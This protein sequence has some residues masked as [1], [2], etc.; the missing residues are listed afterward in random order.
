MIGRGLAVRSLNFSRCA[1]MAMRM[2]VMIQRT[3]GDHDADLGLPLSLDESDA[4]DSTVILITAHSDHMGEGLGSIDPTTGEPI[5][6]FEAEYQQL[7]AQ[8]SASGLVAIDSV[9]ALTHKAIHEPLLLDERGEVVD[10][11][12]ELRRANQTSLRVDLGD[13]ARMSPRRESDRAARE[14]LAVVVARHVLGPIPA[15]LMKLLYVYANDTGR[16]GQFTVKMSTLLDKMGYKRDDRGV[17]RSNNRRAVSQALLALQ[18]T[19]IGIN[20]A[21]EEETV[22]F[23]ASLLSS[24]E[25]RVPE[26]ITTLSAQQVFE[27]GL[28]ETVT[29]TINP[30][31]YRFRDTNGRPTP[32]YSLV[33]R[34]SLQPPTRTRGTNRRP[35]TAQTLGHYLASARPYAKERTLVLTRHALLKQ[36]GITD[37]NR[38][39]ATRTLARAL[40]KLGVDQVL[41]DY[42]PSPLP[43]DPDDKI[44]LVYTSNLFS[45]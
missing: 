3:S 23:V 27:R 2:N 31:W 16:T 19:Q 42:A 33:A 44:T 28:P 25:Y 17:H 35:T 30:R 4:T 39:N 11:G 6:A 20:I 43:L 18:F 38:A 40:D 36:A 37:R 13:I 10:N 14:E 29:I 21:R 34:S 7:I 15:T 12:W 22:G 5:P 9:Y 32:H 1:A 24:L 26:R 41:A 45:E 8:E